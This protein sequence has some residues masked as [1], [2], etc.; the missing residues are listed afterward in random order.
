M[1]DDGKHECVLHPMLCRRHLAPP[2]RTISG[3]LY[4]AACITSKVNVAACSTVRHAM[5]FA[6][7]TNL[8]EGNRISN[9]IV[10]LSFSNTIKFYL[11]L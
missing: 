5:G 4:H 7:P 9:N 10:Y 11:S 1:R 8:A 2:T 3:K 6:T